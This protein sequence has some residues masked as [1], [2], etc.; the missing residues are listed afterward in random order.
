MIEL[1]RNFGH[2]DA[3]PHLWRYGSWTHNQDT[4][5]KPLLAGSR[6]VL[7][8]EITRAAIRAYQTDPR[9]LPGVANGYTY[10]IGLGGFDIALG[11]RLPLEVV[12]T[13]K[14]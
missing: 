7:N 13:L 14:F 12:R 10:G 6:K 1:P 8:Y 5:T 2:L 3:E 4:E 11:K 9:T